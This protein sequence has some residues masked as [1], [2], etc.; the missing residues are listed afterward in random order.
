M[1]DRGLG[2]RIFHEFAFAHP[3]QPGNISPLLP[4][5]LVCLTLGSC[6]YGMIGSTVE[7]R[8]EQFLPGSVLTCADLRSPAI[9]DRVAEV[10]ARLHATPFPELRTY[11]ASQKQA[12]KAPA[13]NSASTTGSASASTSSTSASETV[14]FTF[15]QRW[16]D[17]CLKLTFDEAPT[18]PS[19]AAS[20][21]DAKSAAASPA[22]ST[23][24]SSVA[25]SAQ[26]G[27][28]QPQPATALER[29]R[30]AYDGFGFATGA[31]ADEM[32][33]LKSFL[34]SFDSPICFTH[35]DMQEQNIIKHQ[36]THPT[37]GQAGACACD[38]L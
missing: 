38:V 17:L 32:K 13:S 19:P 2:P 28:S 5:S 12:S 10:M 31:V 6:G 35:N 20:K 29:L 3:S 4:L 15:L 7:G 14:L 16:Y 30:V 8:L 1:S 33:W 36:N 34:L 11:F 23:S 37:T 24:A 22:P 18:P 9:S 26:A 25:T 21:I 27:A